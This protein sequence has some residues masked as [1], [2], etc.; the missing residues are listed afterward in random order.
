[1][2]VTNEGTTGSGLVS[3]EKFSK[4]MPHRI[5]PDVAD[6]AAWLLNPV[7]QDV[8]RPIRVAITKP[9]AIGEPLE[10]PVSPGLLFDLR[11]ADSTVYAY[12]LVDP[13]E[14]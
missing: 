1:V 6:L 11:S 13:R 4:R 12:S 3:T 7:T 8:H 14:F 2:V 5:F 10:F 9:V